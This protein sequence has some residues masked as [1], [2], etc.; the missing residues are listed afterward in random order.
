MKRVKRWTHWNFDSL[1][2]NFVFRFISFKLSEPSHEIIIFA[3]HYDHQNALCNQFIFMCLGFLQEHK[4]RLANVNLVFCSWISKILSASERKSAKEGLASFSRSLMTI[5]TSHCDFANNEFNSTRNLH[6]Y[7][8]MFKWTCS[9]IKVE[10][11][12][13]SKL[14]KCPSVR[15]VTDRQTDKR[16]F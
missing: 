7:C 10:V 14:V 9:E 5:Q 6:H 15:L 16:S 13:L 3:L 12:V 1:L 2:S 8:N 4:Y 11:R